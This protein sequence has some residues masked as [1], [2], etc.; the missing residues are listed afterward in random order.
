MKAVTFWRLCGLLGAVVFLALYLVAITLDSRYTFGKNYLSDLGVGEGANEFN[1][2]LMI[3]GVFYILFSLFGFG[4]VLGNNTEGRIATGMMVLSALLLVTIGIFTENSGDIHGIL[5]H[6]FFL[7][8][9]VTLAVVDFVL[10][11]TKA[12]GWFGV[13]VSLACLVIGV[14]LLPFGGTPLV[15]TIAVLVIIAWGMLISVRL[16]MKSS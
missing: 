15:E 4:P 8:T 9:L 5:S 16:S 13:I 12:L 10:I 11:R 1:A 3:S 2:A 7:E 14:G 6:S